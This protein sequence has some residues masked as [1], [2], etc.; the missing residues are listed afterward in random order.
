[1]GRFGY[2]L[3]KPRVIDYDANNRCIAEFIAAHEPT[4]NLC[5]ECGGCAA[6]CTA[7][8]FTSFSL[9][10]MNILLKRG[11]NS[12]PH[13]KIRRCMMCGKCILVCPRG[14][15]TRNVIA[16]AREAFMKFDRNERL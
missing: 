11:E 13:E 2:T 7:G 10:E 4:F 9:R 5:I 3:S 8:N 16:L 6:T 1:M 14:V 15:N 12:A